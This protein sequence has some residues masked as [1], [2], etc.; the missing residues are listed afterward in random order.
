MAAPA[1]PKG[2][3]YEHELQAALCRGAWADSTPSTTPKAVAI[4]WDELLRKYRK[5]CHAT[6]LAEVASQTQAISLLIAASNTSGSLSSTVLDLDSVTQEDVLASRGECTVLAERIAEARAALTALSNLGEKSPFGTSILLTKA[7]VLLAVGEAQ[8]CIGTLSKVDFDTERKHVQTIPPSASAPASAASSLGPSSGITTLESALSRSGT[9]AG[10][11]GVTNLAKRLDVEVGDGKVWAT[12]ERIRGRCLE[13]MAYEQ[14]QDLESALKAYDAGIP[15]LDR[16]AVSRANPQGKTKSDLFNKYRELWR[17]AE[18]IFRGAIVTAARL[19]PT[20]EAL[21]YLRLYSL[22][23][24]HWPPSFRPICRSVIGSL[25]LRALCLTPPNSGPS[26]L[27]PRMWRDETRR[28]SAELQ[29]ILGLITEFPRAGE[30]NHKVLDFVD[31]CV[32]VWQR[33]GAV[34]S[35]CA[36]VIDVL[37]WA[38]RLTFHS[39]RIMRY[40]SELLVMQGDIV[41]AKRTFKLYIQLV[42]EARQTNAGDVSL[43]LKRRPTEDPAAPPSEISADVADEEDI[44]EDQLR[45]AGVDADS[46]R[47]FISALEWGVTVLARSAKGYTDAKGIEEVATL[48]QTIAAEPALHRNRVLQG[49][50]LRAQGIASMTL[51]LFEPDAKLRPKHQ[52]AAIDFLTSATEMNSNGASTFYQ[53]ALAQA[54]A[55]DIPSAILS[56]RAAVERQPTELRAWHLLGLLLTAQGDW[57]GAKA[58]LQLGVE[59]SVLGDD[60][61]DDVVGDSDGSG[62]TDKPN[63]AD[64]AI[65]RDYAHNGPTATELNSSL[66]NGTDTLPAPSTQRRSLNGSLGANGTPN[67]SRPVSVGALEPLLPFS[68]SGL[69]P[70]GT[71]QVLEHDTPRRT[72]A[73]RFEAGL[74]LRMTQLALTELVGGAE[75]ANLQWPDVFA[76]FSEQCPSA[77]SMGGIHTNGSS[78]VTVVENG[79][80]HDNRSRRASIDGSIARTEGQTH[81]VDPSDDT[82]RTDGT[83]NPRIGDLIPPSP[84]QNEFGNESSTVGIVD[85]EGRH[86]STLQGANGTLPKR[87]LNKSQRQMH[88]IGKR[89]TND[90]KRLEGFVDGSVKVLNKRLQRRN[91]APDFHSGMAGTSSSKT[92][93]A[94]SIHSRS[95]FSTRMNPLKHRPLSSV[96]VDE[97][98]PRPFS[99]PPPLPEPTSPRSK[100]PPRETRL[101]SDLWLTSAATFRRMGKLEQ[102]RAAIQE[103]EVLD[104][105][106]PGVWVQFGLL[107]S[108][109]GEDSLAFESLHKAIVIDQDHVGALVHLAQQYL[110]PTPDSKTPSSGNVDLAAGLL[111]GLTEGQ[112]WDIPEAWYFLA[113]A[114]GL[115]GRREREREC[116]VYALQLQETRCIR[117]LRTAV[118]RCL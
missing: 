50:A 4:P 31:L 115:Q 77:F 116:L 78:H 91:S 15:L 33:G 92:Y 118:P 28:I 2:A 35:E 29:S 67:R 102:A 49:N 74:Q 98:E 51:A 20:T 9:L 5:H 42:S 17:W 55:R 70:S 69:P 46:D 73:D 58:V 72:Y 86:A 37:W 93:Q 57:N 43:Q 32:A 75:S 53:L 97:E 3:H 36:W 27:P 99:P 88:S 63:G 95:R 113:K 105:E 103:A 65:V 66:S 76:Y 114:C 71:L 6:D 24:I 110:K 108:A 96:M 112:G 11:V 89:V 10:S 104:E 39:Q 16:L 100:R 68:T 48:V 47:T 101:L 1:N 90:A 60:I 22:Y 30:V 59:N 25:H 94:S 62:P 82:H 87:L 8:Q 85:D 61:G 41:T 54:G 21:R 13:G 40:L 83:G 7:Y 81:E 45:G 19:R 34:E 84:T 117:S 23:S 12:I 52:K 44:D 107:C 80:I 26:T 106:N 109:R 38:T 111:T 56:A 18:R 64:E 14:L 79:T